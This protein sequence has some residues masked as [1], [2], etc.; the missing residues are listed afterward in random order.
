[1]ASQIIQDHYN[2]FAKRETILAGLRA[3]GKDIAHLSPE[4]LSSFDQ[5]HTAGH[6]ATR[7]LIDLLSPA[8]GQH[9]L[10]V[11]CGIGGPARLLAK[12]TGCR[13]T[14]L[15]LTPHFIAT[16][17]D[18]TERTHQTND[19]VFQV[20]SATALPFASHT[21][22]AAWHIHMSMN[23]ADKAA[24][25][26]EIFRTLKPGARFAMYDPIRGPHDTPTYPVPWAATPATSFLVPQDDMIAL[27][28]TAGFRAISVTD[29]TPEGLAWY[30]D[31]AAARAS[32]PPPTQLPQDPRFLAMSKNHRRN[33][34]TGAVALLR[35]LFARP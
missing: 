28:D 19:I 1:M 23:V 16:A 31:V 4:D 33:L 11:G 14:G 5:L 18:F 20:G 13:V 24:M 8:S 10:D 15:D 21:F 30:A 25:Y 17:K 9:V 3:V 12:T 22:D 6:A 34:E 32:G 29:V 26:A 7:T 27:I 35:G 2:H